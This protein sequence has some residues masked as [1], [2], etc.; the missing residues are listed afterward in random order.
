MVS[1]R[2]GSIPA[3]ASHASPL[4]IAAS[5]HI[6]R[7]PVLPTHHT[8]LLG[9]RRRSVRLVLAA[10][11][12]LHAG[13]AQRLPRGLQDILDLLRTAARG[14]GT[15]DIAEAIGLSGP[16]TTKRLRALETEQRVS[17][18]GKSARDAALTG[19]LHEA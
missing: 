6:G 15:G 8:P 13:Q 19:T 14:L 17:C 11:P 10:L 2:T 16:A 12:R 18:H 9:A 5:A 1:F 4:L 7:A 3:S